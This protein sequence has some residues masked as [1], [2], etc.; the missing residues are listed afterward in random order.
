MDFQRGIL[1]INTAGEN[2]VTSTG[3]QGSGILSSLA[4]ANCYIILGTE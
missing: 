4:K 3:S 1:T 2:V